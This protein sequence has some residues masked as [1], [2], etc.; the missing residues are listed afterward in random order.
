[1]FNTPK[2]IEDKINKLIIP[3]NKIRVYYSDKKDIEYSE[4]C[5]IRAI[6]DDF[7]VVYWT[8]LNRAKR[9]RWQVESKYYFEIRE[10]RLIYRGR[11]KDE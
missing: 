10:D 5:H 9:R 2:H 1:M 4:V 6:V 3:G 7:M 11:C 8:W